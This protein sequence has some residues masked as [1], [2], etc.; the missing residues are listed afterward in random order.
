MNRQLKGFLITST[1][2]TMWG[3]NAVAGKYVMG[4]KGVDPVWMVTLRLILAG[5]VLLGIAIVK[6]NAQ[7]ASGI[8]AL[9]GKV[10]NVFA[11]WKD[12]KSVGRLL[13]IA[14]FAFA[15]CQVSY[16]AAIDLSNAGIATAIQQT[17]PVFVLLSVLVLEKRLP[18]IM[19]II[20]LVTVIFGAF[21]LATGGNLKALIMPANA[22]IL[23][24]I[25]SITCAMYTVLPGKLIRQYGTFATIGWGMLLAG[26]LLIPIAKLWVVSG[27]WDFSTILV[28]SFVIIFGTVMAFATFLYGITIVGPLTGSILGLIEPVVAAFASAIILQQTFLVTDIIGI[29]A[30]LAGVTMLAIYNEKK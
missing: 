3:L 7:D 17:A 23:A 1:G 22:L 26:I 18:K 29:V 24:I 6:D 9:K 27:I 14:V 20:V 10:L 19:E 28:F 16:F 8:V 4:E 13:I 21:M 2:A 15:I 30:I 12:K 11:I 5:I 25:S